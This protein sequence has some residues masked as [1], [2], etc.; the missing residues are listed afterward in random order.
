MDHREIYNGL[1]PRL[2]PT[3]T[4]IDGQVSLIIFY[5]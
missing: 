1:I 5:A 4:E 3:Q 2:T